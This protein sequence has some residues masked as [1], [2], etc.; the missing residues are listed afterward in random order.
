MR[1]GGVHFSY[2]SLERLGLEA[3][4]GTQ[5]AAFTDVGNV[6][7]A[8]PDVTADSATL[9][10]TAGKDAQSNKP[11]YVALMGLDRCRSLA[12]TLLEESLQALN[13]SGLPDTL[14]L[15]QLADMVVCRTR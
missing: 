1:G 11:T 3:L 13:R 5:L 8:A 6:W 4:S 7:F 12:Q 2:P 10:K 9:G 14:A 15:R